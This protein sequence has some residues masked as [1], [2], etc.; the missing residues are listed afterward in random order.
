MCFS[1]KSESGYRGHSVS[2]VMFIEKSFL[3][4]GATMMQEQTEID[5]HGKLEDGL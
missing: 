3:N 1:L 5:V 4:L 2:G